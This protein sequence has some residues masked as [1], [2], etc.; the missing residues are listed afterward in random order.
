ED[1]N[2][3]MIVSGRMTPAMTPKTTQF[4]SQAVQRVFE[5]YTTQAVALGDRLARLQTQQTAIR[6]EGEELNDTLAKLQAEA[7]AAQQESEQGIERLSE[8]QAFA[9]RVV[10]PSLGVGLFAV[11]VLS[12]VLALFGGQRAEMLPCLVTAGCSFL[13]LA[14]VLVYGLRSGAPAW[15]VAGNKSAPE[16][17][18]T[19][20]TSPQTLGAP[21]ANVPDKRPTEPRHGADR[22]TGEPDFTKGDRGDDGKPGADAPAKAP[23]PPLGAPVDNMRVARGGV[24]PQSALKDMDKGNAKGEAKGKGAP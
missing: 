8:Y 1:A 5:E 3:L 13:L 19:A 10:L 6:A 14:G 22:K 4:A 11:C 9:R 16:G 18:Q 2:R 15:Q 20:T 24:D 17:A 7:R 12:L 23:A 21:D